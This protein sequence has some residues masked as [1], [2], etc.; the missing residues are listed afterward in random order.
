MSVVRLDSHPRFRPAAEAPVRRVELQR[1]L[2]VGR[3]TIFEYLK[4]GMPHV[5]TRSQNLF[6]PSECKAW[7]SANG[8]WQYD[9]GGLSD[10]D[11]MENL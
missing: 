4:A 9:G 8:F 7:L 11:R 2:G 3:T 5:K 1:I 6:Y 10:P